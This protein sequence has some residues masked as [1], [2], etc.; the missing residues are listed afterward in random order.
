MHLCQSQEAWVCMSWPL[1]GLQSPL[2]KAPLLDQHHRKSKEGEGGLG[3]NIVRVLHVCQL[4]SDFI[5]TPALPGL[6][7]HFVLD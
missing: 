2:V 1:L 7:D 4:C 6:F 3:M 5:L